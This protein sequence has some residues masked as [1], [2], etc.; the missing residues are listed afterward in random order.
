MHVA[1]PFGRSF[2]EWSLSRDEVTQFLL[3]KRF[4]VVSEGT[5][6]EDPYTDHPLLLVLQ[7]A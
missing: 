1:P 3:E 4:K 5:F 7:K 2:A 6:D